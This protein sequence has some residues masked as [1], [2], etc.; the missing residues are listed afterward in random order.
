MAAERIWK[1]L[2][3]GLAALAVAASLNTL[4]SAARYREIVIRKQADW[5]QI[6]GYADR[7]AQEDAF[8]QQ[9][10][11]RQA[12]VPAELEDLATRTLGAGAVQVA[13]RPAV[14]VGANWQRREAAIA[15]RDVAYPQVESFLSAL[16]A[17]PPPWRL[18]EVDIKPGTEPG[19]GSMTL[20][21]EALEKKQP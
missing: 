21:V 19:G 15:L 20:V 1:G 2:A 9:L 12:W 13:P 4:L 7:W 3:I 6:A 16:A 14:A 5:Q 11:A 10:D 8:R 17:N 18:R